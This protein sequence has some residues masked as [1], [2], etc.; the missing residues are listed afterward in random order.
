V[1]LV[2]APEWDKLVQNLIKEG[3]LHSSRVIETMRKIP[4]EKFLPENMRSY[5]AVDTP[6]P[7]GFSQTASAPHMVAIMNEALQLE[8][9]HKVLEVGAGSGWHAATI[10][11]LVAPRTAPRSEWGHV[12]TVEIVQGLSDFSR[13]NIMNSGYGDRVTII[14]GDG[15]AG[16]SEKA[17]YDRILATAAAPSVPKPLV[18]QLKPEGIMLIPVGSLSLFQNLIKLTKT[19]DGKTKEENLGGVAFVP[20]TGKYGQQF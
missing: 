18:E 20:L 17:P 9:G 11:E 1:D 14:H 5:G 19:G 10:G 16:Y 3:V 6:L 4:R 12:Y 2:E 7:I 13:K 8:I 15:S